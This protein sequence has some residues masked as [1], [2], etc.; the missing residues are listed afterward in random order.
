MQSP[1]PVH[2]IPARPDQQAFL[3][4]CRRHLAIS[5]AKTAQDW[6]YCGHAQ[7]G[8]GGARSTRDGSGEARRRVGGVLKY[9]GRGRA[10][11]PEGRGVAGNV[12]AVWRGGACQNFVVELGFW[13]E[14]GTNVQE[15]D[16]GISTKLVCGRKYE[17]R[18]FG[19]GPGG[20]V[21]GIPAKVVL[22]LALDF[23]L[24]KQMDNLIGNP[25]HASRGTAFPLQQTGLG[26]QQGRQ[27]GKAAGR[28]GGP[29]L[30]PRSA[31][32]PPRGVGQQQG[33]RENPLVARWFITRGVRLRARGL[34]L[35]AG[36]TPMHPSQRG[37]WSSTLPP[38]FA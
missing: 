1:A 4:N 33:R 8:R 18:G 6:Q 30:S 25:D 11:P 7:G 12:L 37:T 27:A 21:A 26:H 17:R 15:H 9:P 14:K 35:A 36:P 2:C 23:S 28:Q 13:T 10:P 34:G 32:P 20:F 3:H 38:R 22:P 16:R 19:C 31:R 24:A 29:P 5:H